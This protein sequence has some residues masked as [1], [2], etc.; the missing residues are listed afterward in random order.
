MLLL[1]PLAMVTMLALTFVILIDQDVA[2][3]RDA[4]IMISG[5]TIHHYTETVLAR[6][7]TGSGFIDVSADV[8]Y[9]VVE[10]LFTY[11][12]VDGDTR[13]YVTWPARFTQAGLGVDGRFSDEE[14]SQKLARA[15]SLIRSDRNFPGRT[16]S[17]LFSVSGSHDGGGLPPGQGGTPPGQ[18]GTPPGQGGTPPGQGGT[19]V[20][21]DSRNIILPFTLPAQLPEGAPILVT[22]V[23]AT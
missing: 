19:G 17:G 15:S 3:E 14:L 11:V 1:I 21:V 10:D 23:E 13:I 6:S 9:R 20:S 16:L 5:Q 2:R 18:G 4:T 8:F 12:H 7:V 22:V